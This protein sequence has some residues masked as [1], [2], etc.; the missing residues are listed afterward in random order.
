MAFTHR[1]RQPRHPQNGRSY[2][3]PMVCGHSS[4]VTFH[5]LHI[6][7]HPA[8]WS[9][10]LVLV[11]SNLH[12][13]PWL[14]PHWDKTTQD[15]IYSKPPVKKTTLVKFW[16]PC[17]PKEQFE[18]ACSVYWWPARITDPLWE[19]LPLDSP[20]RRNDGKHF[21]LKTK[22]MCYIFVTSLH[23]WPFVKGIRRWPVDSPN[24]GLVTSN[25]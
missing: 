19:E 16:S 2:F 18:N 4:R 11:R 17:W 10:F 25:L 9:S 22:S 1:C 23:Y 7:H 5:L 8:K 24:K 12:H 13:R 15:K 3:H 6:P 21:N 14:L 20:S